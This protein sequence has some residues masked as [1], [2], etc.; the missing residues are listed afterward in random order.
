MTNNTNSH[1]GPAWSADAQTLYPA[2]KWQLKRA[3][4]FNAAPGQTLRDIG[5]VLAA[6]ALGFVLLL[7]DPGLAGLA[8]AFFTLTLASLHAG[9]IVHDAGHGLVLGDR[10]L[11]TLFG[12]VFLTFLTGMSY[13]EYL[14][15]HRRHHSHCNEKKIVP[16]GRTGIF[17]LREEVIENRFGATRRLG[18]L[19]DLFNRYQAF[20]IWIPLSLKGFAI[21]LDG[22]RFALKC[23]KKAGMYGVFMLLHIVLWFGVPA[24]VLGP[25]QALVNY[26][27]L[28]GLCGLYIGSIFLLNHFATQIIR[29]DQRP[30]YFEQQM[31]AT[32]NL[33][34]GWLDNFLLGGFN[35]HIEHHLF[36]TIPKS[37]LGDARK[38]THAFCRSHGI[39]Y[40][41]TSIGAAFRD[42]FRHFDAMAKSHAAIA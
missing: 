28:T 5:L 8:L 18:A 17:S 14:Y 11:T 15:K 16:Q 41:E 20:L 2:L 25:W 31:V 24:S 38:I 10:R 3:G 7:S 42:I 21:K 9:I 33:G 4:C 35:H 36:P 1:T 37:R 27:I 34:S 40:R 32:R 29:P 6:Y 23:P 22:V 26:A 12:H 19:R 30:H 13:D 39:P